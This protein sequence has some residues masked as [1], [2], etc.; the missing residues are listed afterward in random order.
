MAAEAGIPFMALRAIADPAWH[1]L[2][3]AALL[4]LDEHGRPRLGAVFGSI[5]K[6]PG[7]IPGLIVTAFDTRAALKALLR[8]GRVLAV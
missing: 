7:Q 8:A 4:P 6:K 5:M 1:G 3:A 2:P